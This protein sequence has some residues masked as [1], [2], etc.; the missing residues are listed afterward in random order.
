MVAGLLAP[1]DNQTAPSLI[2]VNVN[3]NTLAPND[4][5]TGNEAARG[6][7]NEDVIHNNQLREIL[8]AFLAVSQY[9]KVKI[10]T[11]DIAPSLQALANV[12]RTEQT[13]EKYRLQCI[14]AVQSSYRLYDTYVSYVRNPVEFR[15]E[16][17][18]NKINL[19][20]YKTREKFLQ[21]FVV[22]PPK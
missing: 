18:D 19:N 4:N 10:S 15:R 1:N 3:S 6:N 21:K 16:N 22:T 13:F 7:N 9:Y 20:P 17:R 2:D 11:D 8:R 12:C 5:Q 14:V